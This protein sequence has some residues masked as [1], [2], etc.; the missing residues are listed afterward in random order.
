[1]T[2]SSVGQGKVFLLNILFG[3]LCVILFDFFHVLRAK[4]GKNTVIINAL[5]GMYFI[6]AFAIIL[7]AGVKFNFGALRYYQLTGLFIGIGLQSLLSSVVRKCMV[8]V[9]DFLSRIVLFIGKITL[10]PAIF[11]LRVVLTPICFAEKKCMQISGK[12]INR[13]KKVKKKRNKVKKTVK[14]RIKMI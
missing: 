3:M 10:K 4:Y 11:I 7:F 9:Y 2:V 8:R 14:K 5:D 1:M 12:M 6:L 13:Y